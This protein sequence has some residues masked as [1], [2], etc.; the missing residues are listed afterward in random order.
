MTSILL[1]GDTHG[2]PGVIKRVFEEAVEKGCVAI[3][4]LGDFGFGWSIGEDGRCD[5][6][7]LTAAFAETT[8]IPFYFIDGNHENFDI[9]YQLPLDENGHRPIMEGVTHLPRGSVITF[10]ETTFLCFGGAY[11]V[12]KDQRKIGKSWWP[13]EQASHAE[14]E[15]AMNQ[16]A[17]VLL[18]HDAPFGIQSEKEYG[19]LTRTFG[20]N[21]TLRSQANQRV[22]REVFDASGAKECFHGHL[23]RHWTR[24]IGDGRTVVGLNA[25]GNKKSTLVLDV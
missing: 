19:W 3:V 21:A 10:G 17:H 4:Q 16:R 11:S 9:L 7:Y 25:D 12:D 22:V 13:Q 24:P 5:F 6:S 18:S 14:I 20:E 2:N 1:V 8:G 23:H 15:A